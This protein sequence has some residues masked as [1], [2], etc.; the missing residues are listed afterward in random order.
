M[1]ITAENGGV[2]LDAFLSEY[3]GSR[4]AAER[5]I[6]AGAVTV[7]NRAERSS[8]KVK[9]GDLIDCSEVEPIAADVQPE[10]ISLAIVYEDDD[11]IVIDKPKGMVVHPAPGHYS[12]T[13]VNA[14]MFHCGSS[15]S[16]YSPPTPPQRGGKDD[17]APLSEGGHG[18]SAPLSEGGH[19]GSVIVRPGI[20]HRIDKDT[21]GLL[22][23]AKN[24]NAHRSL[25]SQLA[26]RSLSR[27]YE[28]VI[29]GS[30]KDLSGVIDMPVGRNPR[31]RK[32]MAVVKSGGRNAVTHW[33]LIARYKGYSHLRC[34]LETG[35][36]HQIRVHLAA[37][38]HP[39]V[40]DALYGSAKNQF[41][42]E[43]Q[44]LHAREL[45]LIHPRSGEAM[46]FS[47]PLP[48]YFE[49]VLKKLED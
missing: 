8:Y 1:K 14:L 26:E 35:R 40:G 4:S 22:V 12:G 47:A 42:L 3:A 38:G 16:G 31:D 46:S 15:L 41:G 9:S 7:N 19:G 39:V 37:L 21:S 13:L 33:E 25:S 5:L 23:A 17:N 30:F 27:T 28:T 44:C 34:K 43:G 45:R 6:S 32:K 18:G 20:V 10:N 24:D 29:I 2:R 36:T 11:I 48:D 49:S